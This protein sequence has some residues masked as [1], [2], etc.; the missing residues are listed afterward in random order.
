[1][2]TFK[3]LFAFIFLFFSYSALLSQEI[4]KLRL[5]SIIT[6]GKN[7]KVEFYYNEK[8]QNTSLINFSWSTSLMAY[9]L[10][11]KKEFSY[12]ENGQC[13]SEHYYLWDKTL[14]E[15]VVKNRTDKSYDGNGQVLL[16]NYYQW[17]K[18]ENKWDFMSKTDY[19]NTYNIG[20]KQLEY[21]TSFTTKK[22]STDIERKKWEFGSYEDGKVIR[23]YNWQT[24]NW[25]E[26]YKEYYFFGTN[27]VFIKYSGP[28]MSGQL[29]YDMNFRY[30]SLV[31]PENYLFDD[32][33]LPLK[34]DY[35]YMITSIVG[36]SGLWTKRYYYSPMII[37]GLNNQ[38]LSR[39]SVFPNPATDFINI[40]WTGN[41]Q[42]MNVELYDIAGRKVLNAK[43]HNNSRLSVKHYRGGIYLI[44][45]VDENNIIHKEKISI[46]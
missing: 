5:D 21:I 28:Q 42:N 8:G 3:A 4:G 30:S 29:T 39:I 40:Q 11:E 13:S 36:F 9:E 24:N 20:N 34:Y 6:V 46:K 17:I 16:S 33:L 27:Q 35:K 38:E 15:W 45:I 44:N 37:T 19:S 12:N 7:T 23:L 25:V 10:K 22:G 2:K 43:I 31:V 14:N 1:M 18:E 41:Q 26:T 32:C